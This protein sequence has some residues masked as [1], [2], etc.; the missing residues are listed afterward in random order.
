MIIDYLD[1]IAKEA[2]LTRSK[3]LAYIYPQVVELELKKAFGKNPKLIKTL[4][5]SDG[6]STRAS[7]AEDTPMAFDTPIWKLIKAIC[8]IVQKYELQVR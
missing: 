2:E 6:S 1:L 5:K 3:Y 8:K 4:S 7:I